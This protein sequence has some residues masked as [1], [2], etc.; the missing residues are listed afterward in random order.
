LTNEIYDA[1]VDPFLIAVVAEIFGRKL[2]ED[3]W[4]NDYETIYS[5]ISA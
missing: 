4:K 2:Q 5:G 1:C 3:I